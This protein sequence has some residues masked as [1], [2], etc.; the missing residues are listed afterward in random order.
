VQRI[1]IGIPVDRPAQQQINEL[2]IPIRK[3][4]KDIHWVPEQNRHLTLA[5][6]GKTPVLVIENLARSMQRAYQQVSVFQSGSATL[7]RF[8]GSTGHIVALVLKEDEYLAHLFHITQDFLAE[9]GLVCD[10]NP[11][12][13]HITLGR[14]RKNP[15]LKIKFS[16]QTNINLQVNKIMLYQSTL[17][18]AG[19]AYLVL[20]E[21]EFAQR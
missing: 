17:T 13:P 20:K 12:R 21:I 19:R 10:R 11:F 3:A 15:L 1:F 9:N 5:F 7:C 18:P 2:L 8:P 6:L 14:I 16:Q 4:Y